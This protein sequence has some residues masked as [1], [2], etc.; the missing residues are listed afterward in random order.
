MESIEC[1][2]EHKHFHHLW[3]RPVD[4]NLLCVTH[5]LRRDRLRQDA[6]TSV[7][8]SLSYKPSEL[9][10]KLVQVKSPKHVHFDDL[11]RF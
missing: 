1:C 9:D 5:V 6:A 10:G 3:I 11:I 7:E 4:E 8:L 2:I